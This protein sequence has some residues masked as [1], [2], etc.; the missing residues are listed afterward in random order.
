MATSEETQHPQP[1]PSPLAQA[2]GPSP[3]EK[4]LEEN[5]A[6]VILAIAGVVALASAWIL[7]SGLN[8]EKL[9]EA[10]NAY[11][12]AKTVADL[13]KVQEQFPGTVIAGNALLRKAELLEDEGD[14]DGAKATLLKFRDQFREHPRFDQALVVLGRMAEDAGNLAQAETFLNE[15]SPNSDVAPLAKIHL[16][17]LAMQEGDYEKARNIYEPIQQEYPMNAWMGMWQQ[18]INS[19]KRLVPDEETLKSDGDAEEASTGATPP[20]DEPAETPKEEAKPE[21]PTTVESPG[22][23]ES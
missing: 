23:A 16:G 4:Y 7:F 1:D 12:E 13:D 9:V 21:E 8:S 11:S 6:G 2:L 18:R 10:G 19:L 14:L 22:D 5:R 20:V 3:I 15:V 17:D